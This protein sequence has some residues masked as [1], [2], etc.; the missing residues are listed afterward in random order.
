[1]TAIPTASPPHRSACRVNPFLDAGSHLSLAEV[2][3]ERALWRQ[4]AATG[5]LDA[6][7]RARWEY[8][9]KRRV[10]PIYPPVDK[11]PA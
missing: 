5:Y 2:A 9:R 6:L 10:P 7:E 8:L 3:E 4:S 1:M 11:V